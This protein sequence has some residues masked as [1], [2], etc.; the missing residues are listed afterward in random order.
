M[1]VRVVEVERL[2]HDSLLPS[3]GIHLHV[4]LHTLQFLPIH[5]CLFVLSFQNLL[6]VAAFFLVFPYQILQLQLEVLPQFLDG[7]LFINSS[8]LS[9]FFYDPL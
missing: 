8:H 4:F 1:E 9:L 5:I 3:E 7:I 2:L 6:I